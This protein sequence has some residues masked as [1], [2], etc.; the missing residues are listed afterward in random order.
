MKL[1]Q[2]LGYKLTD[3]GLTK[4]TRDRGN[5]MSSE[6]ACLPCVEE[7]DVFDILGL[8]YLEPHQRT[9]LR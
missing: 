5:N 1:A 9:A 3:T 8:P 6:G 7:K 2:D 4:C